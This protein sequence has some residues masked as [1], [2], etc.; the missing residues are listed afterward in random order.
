MFYSCYSHYHISNA[1]IIAT[2][3]NSQE[4]MVF[5]WRFALIQSYFLATLRSTNFFGP[6]WPYCGAQK[7][8][9]WHFVE[10]CKTFYSQ[11]L[12]INLTSIYWYMSSVFLD[13]KY[14]SVNVLSETE[15]SICDCVIVQTWVDDR[16]PTWWIKLVR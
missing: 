14:F 3:W 6:P 5:E 2:K 8:K 7:L 15:A 16:K 11:L 4:R 9:I 10:R 12:E 13:V 1:G